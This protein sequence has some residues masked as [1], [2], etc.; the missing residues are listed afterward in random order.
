M[1]KDGQRGGIGGEDDNLR[2]TSVEGLG[3]LVGTLLE[4]AVVAGL[5]H[6]VEDLLGEGL[7]GDGPCGGFGGHDVGWW[8]CVKLKGGVD[9]ARPD[10]SRGFTAL[11][12]LYGMLRESQRWRRKSCNFLTKSGRGANAR[13]W[14]GPHAG[15]LASRKDSS[16]CLAVTTALQLSPSPLIRSATRLHQPFPHHVVSFKITVDLSIFRKTP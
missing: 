13:L 15:T 8:W 16:S 6:K 11:G 3:G 14:S 5:L 10:N 7:V 2:D 9:K 4:L 1:E 12:L